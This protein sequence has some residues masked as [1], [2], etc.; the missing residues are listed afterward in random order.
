M[1]KIKSEKKLKEELEKLKTKAPR[2]GV[3]PTKVIP[4]KTKYSRKKKHRK[5]Y[6]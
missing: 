2:S 4:D 1:K 3:H 5:E 6:E